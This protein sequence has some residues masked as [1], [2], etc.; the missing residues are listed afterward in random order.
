MRACFDERIPCQVIG[1][2]RRLHDLAQLRIDEGFEQVVYI[3]IMVVEGIAVDAAALGDIGDGHL[4][5]RLFDKQ[6]EE[7]VHDGAL[8]ESGHGRSYGTS[9]AS[10]GFKK[11]L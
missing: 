5:Q 10:A 7:G 8:G 3:V 6:F 2:A 4:V 1:A 9:P 11:R